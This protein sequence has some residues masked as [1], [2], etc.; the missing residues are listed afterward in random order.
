MA[1]PL[2]AL[3]VA[4]S[5]SALAQPLIISFVV[6]AVTFSIAFSLYTVMFPER[7]AADRLE[8]LIAAEDENALQDLTGDRNRTVFAAIAERLGRIAQQGADQETVDALRDTLQHAGYKSRRAL[9]IF[10]G[11]RLALL[12]LAPVAASLTGYMFEPMAVLFAMVLSAALGYYFPVIWLQSRAQE[13]KAELVKA[14]P[15]SLDLL[16]SCVDA[17]LSLDQAFRRV[18]LEL[19][20]ISPDL[21]REFNLVNSEVSAGIERPVAMRHLYDRTG[22]DEVR[23]LVNMLTQAEK[24]GTSIA[25]SLRIYS[26]VAREKRMARAEEA[27]GSV[28]TKLTGVMIVFFLPVLIALLGAPAA[29]RIFWSG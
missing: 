3:V 14:L 20:P 19:E 11:T 17:G 10:N 24:Y 29:I 27:A 6:V 8:A 12:V 22:V 25:N 9:E 5:A 15:D 1:T 7:T 21:A 23:S 4:A 28:S 16:I 2:P 26:T 13:R 18:A